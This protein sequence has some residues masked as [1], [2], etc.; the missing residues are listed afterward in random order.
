MPATPSGLL[1]A[2]SA[3]GSEEHGEARASEEIVVATHLA[4]SAHLARWADLNS[5]CR[6]K[7]DD[8]GQQACIERDEL[9][10]QLYQQG[11]CYGEG[12]E[13]GSEAEWKPCRAAPADNGLSA[14]EQAEADRWAAAYE[15]DRRIQAEVDRQLT[16]AQR[17][18]EQRDL[19]AL[20]RMP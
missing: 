1:A 2:C 8:E 7:Y 3:G 4:T 5:T 17:A 10:Q 20:K 13:F 19:E 6:D 11:W 16:A 15:R 18:Q 12:V 14:S 9:S